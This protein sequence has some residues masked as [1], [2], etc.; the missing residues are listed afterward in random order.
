[1][2]ERSTEITGV[3]K[4]TLGPETS[5][6]QQVLE[7]EDNF[8]PEDKGPQLEGDENMNTGALGTGRTPP[9]GISAPT[10]KLKEVPHQHL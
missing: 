10:G 6:P 2:L 5:G 8:D 1:M 9:G 7:Q 4:A 3:T